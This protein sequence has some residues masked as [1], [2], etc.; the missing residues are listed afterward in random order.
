M[1]YRHFIA[2]FLIVLMVP[3]CIADTLEIGEAEKF[4]QE[5]NKLQE[6]NEELISRLEKYEEE[7]EKNRKT[8]ELRNLI[9][10]Q[11]REIFQAMIKGDTEQIMQHISRDAAIEDNQFVYKVGSE[12]ITIPFMKEGRTFRQRSYQLDDEGQFIT[13]YEVWRDDQEGYGGIL[14][15]TFTLENNDWKL[16]SIQTDM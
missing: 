5:I 2:L 3:G 11:A 12:M 6:Q 10:M 1:N 4:I 15:L 9:D 13:E 14:Q 8:Y 7:V 16:K